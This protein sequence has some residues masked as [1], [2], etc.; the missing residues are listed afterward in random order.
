VNMLFR[1]PIAYVACAN[2]S[3]VCA[4]KALINSSRSIV[5]SFGLSAI[6]SARSVLHVRVRTS[7]DPQRA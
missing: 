1:A 5:S 2:T 3:A 4:S 7:A 6:H